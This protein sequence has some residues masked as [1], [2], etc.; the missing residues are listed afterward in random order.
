VFRRN[1]R[2]PD[3]AHEKPPLLTRL[4]EKERALLEACKLLTTAIKEN[5]PNMRCRIDQCNESEFLPAGA[6]RR[7]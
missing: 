7:E 5:R 4:A 2:I 1:R 6:M 3:Y